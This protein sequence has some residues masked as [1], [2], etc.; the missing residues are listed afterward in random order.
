M[1]EEL[2][3]IKTHLLAKYNTFNKG[4]ANVSKPNQTELIIDSDGQSFCGI[5]DNEGN[6]FYIRSL[7]KSTYDPISRGARVAFYKRTTECR[8]VAIHLTASEED[9]ETILVNSVSSNAHVVTNTDKEK[10]RVFFDETGAK[11][12]HKEL[13]LVSCDFNVVDTVSTKNCELNPCDC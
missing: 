8:I 10:T 2:E 7:K 3:N 4:Y 13:T 12:T 6:Y 1:I 5:S 9:I 11:L